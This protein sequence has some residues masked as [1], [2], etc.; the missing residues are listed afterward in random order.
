MKHSFAHSLM[1]WILIFNVFLSGCGTSASVSD[2]PPVY[3][4]IQIFV[5]DAPLTKT[6]GSEPLILDISNAEQGYFTAISDSTD[7]KMNVQLTAED[8]VVYSYFIAPGEK[9][10]IPFS[11]GSGTYQIYCY[12][13]I[14]GTQYAALFADTLNV[15]L[16]NEFLPFL[17]PNQ[18]VNFNPGSEV[19]KLARSLVPEDASDIDTL[20]AVYDYV[21]QNL[22]Y[23][24]ALADTVTSGYLPDLDAVL[25]SKK[26]ICFD[27]AALT[28]A[29]LRSRDIPCKLQIGYAGKI[30]HAWINVYIRSKGW[31]EKAVEFSGN[32]WSRMDPT[33]DSNS[34]DKENIQTYIRD[35]DNYTVQ[36]TR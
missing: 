5:P 14:S 11:S 7:L 31:V 22:T 8:D 18:Y 20:E 27:Y 17:Y 30:K 19:C 3:S 34:E 29:M 6:L 26:G 35:D 10:V 36:F 32:S 15:T 13:Q 9:A 23:D 2:E 1:I 33:F 12:Q 25:A 16:E 28:A 4:S 21:T 24:Q